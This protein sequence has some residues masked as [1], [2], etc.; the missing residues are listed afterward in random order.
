MLEAESSSRIGVA[1]SQLA[2]L[3]GE[4]LL[5]LMTALETDMRQRAAV[6]HALIAELDARGV[7]MELGCTST[8]VLLSERLRIGRREAAGRSGWPRRSVHAA[9]CRERR[10]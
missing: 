9:P 1:L 8:A 3:S 5:E 4:E 6:T 2:A 7:A 10:C